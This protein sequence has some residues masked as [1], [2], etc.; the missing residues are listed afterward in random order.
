V[1][2]ESRDLAGQTSDA[3]PAMTKDVLSRAF[4]PFFTAAVAW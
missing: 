3:G 1:P 4:E 2:I